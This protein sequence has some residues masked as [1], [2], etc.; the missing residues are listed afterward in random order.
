MSRLLAIETATDHASVALVVDG[1]LRL[2]EG[3]AV[4]RHT[5]QVAPAITEL[6]AE[7]GIGAA[8]LDAIAVD[9]GPGLFTGLRV[10][11]ATA[12]SLAAVLELPVV[13]A[14]STDL[15]AE[16]AAELGQRGTLAVG[17][18]ARRGEVFAATYELDGHAT[19]SSAISCLE[20]EA[21]AVLAAGCDAT[22]GDGAARY[23]ERLGG[24]VLLASP[25]RPSAATL[26][27]VGLAK[28]EAGELQAANAVQPLYLREPDAVANFAVRGQ[29]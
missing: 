11:L 28:L 21:F 26:A 19:P 14:R 27:R 12:I 2:R 6:L 1:E 25:L 15:V 4:Q 22:A 3:G 23:A 29:R 20:P 10:G 16:A 8:D 17:V 5:E 24:I 7:A 9:H 13:T 18:D